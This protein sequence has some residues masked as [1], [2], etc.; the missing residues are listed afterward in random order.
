MFVY[1]CVVCDRTSD[2]LVMLVYDCVACDRISNVSVMLVYD[3][4]SMTACMFDRHFAIIVM[5]I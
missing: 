4:L 3:V 2:V 1:D 5:S